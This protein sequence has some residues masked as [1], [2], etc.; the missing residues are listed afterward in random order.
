[1]R[2]TLIDYM[3]D[4]KRVADIASICYGKDEAKNPDKLFDKLVEMGHHSVLEHVVFTF[5]IEGVSRTLLSQL[6]R[7]RIASV[8]VESQRYTEYDLNVGYTIPD[9][10]RQNKT[11]N[12]MYHSR[13]IEGILSYRELIDRGVPK[14]DARMALPQSIHTN[15]YLT[16]NL[17]SLMNLVR[18]RTSQ[19]AQWEIRELAEK[20][21]NLVYESIGVEI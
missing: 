20:M 8:T 18:L 11:L 9:S 3:G 14:E 7:H 10:I 1:M 12:Q 6:T 5:K 15:L 13:M 19:W 16:I 21:R 17:R 2:V 4:K